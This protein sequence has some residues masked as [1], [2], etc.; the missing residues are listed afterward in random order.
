MFILYELST[1][2]LNIHWFLDKLDM[3]GSR[4]QLYNGIILITSFGCCRLLWGTYQ[5][6]KIYSD[7]WKA[8]ESTNRDAFSSL[9][10]GNSNDTPE[11]RYQDDKLSLSLAILY[12]ASN[13]ILLFLN[14]Y[15][16]RAMIQAIT[17][18]FKKP[19]DTKSIEKQ[20]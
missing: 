8:V 3:T 13:T 16:F 17:K 12:L 20:R 14:F 7:I 5:S 15:W 4:P 11:G 9:P 10:K 18:R 2:F 19:K 1:P 6:Y